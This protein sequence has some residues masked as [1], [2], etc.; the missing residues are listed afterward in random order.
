MPMDSY[1]TSLPNNLSGQKGR[2]NM[3]LKSAADSTDLAKLTRKTA[4]GE[5]YKKA[6]N[7]DKREINRAK[8]ETWISFVI[9]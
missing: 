9:P 3:V 4:D 5:Q 7:E 8:K 6:F 2:P 1:T